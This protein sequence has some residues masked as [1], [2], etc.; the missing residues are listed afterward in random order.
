MVPST[1]SDHVLVVVSTNIL[2]DKQKELATNSYKISAGFS[3][4]KFL[5][6]ISWS[7][8]QAEVASIDWSFRDALN[9]YEC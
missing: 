3:G 2:S 1:L 9:L 8:R 5:S 7:K 6:E 4:L